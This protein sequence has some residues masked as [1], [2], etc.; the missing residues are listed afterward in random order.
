MESEDVE[1]I[2]IKF[3]GDVSRGF[4]AVD[5]RVELFGR[6][7]ENYPTS[8]STRFSQR[9]LWPSQLDLVPIRDKGLRNKMITLTTAS[10]S[11]RRSLKQVA[12][13]SSSVEP[14]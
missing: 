7:W 12:V 13:A 9:L 5:R 3:S 4:S 14:S 1:S 8:H 6:R 2:G 10:H 11:R